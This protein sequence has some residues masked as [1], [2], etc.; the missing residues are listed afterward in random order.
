M[1]CK[2]NQKQKNYI[3]YGVKIKLGTRENFVD[4][5][6]KEYTQAYRLGSVFTDIQL[7]IWN[8]ASF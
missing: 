7:Y 5:W 1:F 6:H 3:D 8:F 2:Y 4:T